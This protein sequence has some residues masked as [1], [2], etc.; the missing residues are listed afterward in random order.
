MTSFEQP[1]NQSDFVNITFLESAN[2]QTVDVD[3]RIFVF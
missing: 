1:G 2:L 3:I